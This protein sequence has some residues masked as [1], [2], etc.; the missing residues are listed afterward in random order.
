ME[1]KFSQ[2][3]LVEKEKASRN[4]G[5]EKLEESKQ[6]NKKAKATTI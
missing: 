6:T 1:N 3:R 4:F 5:N 2:E